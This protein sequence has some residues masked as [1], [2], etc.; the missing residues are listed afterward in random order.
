[1][2]LKLAVSTEMMCGP[3]GWLYLSKVDTAGDLAG[4]IL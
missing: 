1:M 4:Q 2:V 3:H